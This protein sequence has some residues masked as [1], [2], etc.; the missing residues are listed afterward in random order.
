MSKEAQLLL[1]EVKARVPELMLVL[2]LVAEARAALD[3]VP[4]RAYQADPHC[5]QCQRTTLSRWLQPLSAQ[6]R[7]T[8]GDM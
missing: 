2:G 5:R 7:A 8:T 3:R 4:N 1:A 6:S